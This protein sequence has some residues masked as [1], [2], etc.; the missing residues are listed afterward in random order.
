M[1]KCKYCQSEIDEKAKICPTCKKDLRNYFAKH[2]VIT[3]ILIVFIVGTIGLS[4]EMNNTTKTSTDGNLKTNEALKETK[5][6]DIELT[7]GKYIVGEEVVPGKY[8]VQAIKGMGNFFVYN[9]SEILG[10]KV[11][12]AFSADEKQS[13]G[14]FGSTYNN[15]SLKQG[16]IIETNSNLVI[17][18]IAK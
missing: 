12:Q 9:E 11:N 2:K 3:F 17:K 13:N 15:L 7:P 14:L 6:V 5:G 1:K 8:D 16:D 18:L 10:L 4:N